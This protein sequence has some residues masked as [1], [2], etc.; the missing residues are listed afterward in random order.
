MDCA[1]VTRTPCNKRRIN[2]EGQQKQE[3]VHATRYSSKLVRIFHNQNNCS[4]SKMISEGVGTDCAVVTR[5]PCIA[6]RQR[7][8]TG[9]NR[10]EEH[11]YFGTRALHT[12]PIRW[13]HAKGCEHH[14]ET[15][16]KTP[17]PACGHTAAPCTAMPPKQIAWRLLHTTSSSRSATSYLCVNLCQPQLCQCLQAVTK[18][19]P[20][21]PC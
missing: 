6:T 4:S 10:A 18:L 14:T 8:H 1:V 5:T 16:S 13:L 7:S 3:W 20:A 2:S 9:K 11:K 17:V 12:Q 15:D 21:Q 19:A